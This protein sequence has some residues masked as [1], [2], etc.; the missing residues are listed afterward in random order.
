MLFPKHLRVE[1]PSHPGEARR[2]AAAL[3]QQ[4]GFGELRSAEVALMVTELATNLVKH[5]A[6]AGGELVFCPIQESGLSGLDMLSLDQGPGIANI[7]ESL[8]DGHST[9]G[10]LGTALTWEDIPV[11]APT[12][13]PP[14]CVC[15]LMSL[16]S[17]ASA[18]T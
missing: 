5:T 8:R 12:P 9:A 17:S 15:V 18:T 10:S 6:G 11:C 14:L 1:D 2:L 16:F 13:P 3:C 4:L 7:G